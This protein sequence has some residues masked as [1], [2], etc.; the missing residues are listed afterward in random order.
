MVNKVFLIGNLTA[1]PEVRASQS[2]TYVANVRIATNVYAGKGE[3]GSRKEVTDFHHVVFFGKQAET[4]GS[5]MHKGTQIFV[6][7]RL[8]TSSWDD[9][10]SGQKRYRTE[11]IGEEFRLLGSKPREAAA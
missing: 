3:D 6:E 11:V 9:A 2:G 7:G 4:A 1:D 5:Y 8:H 10:A